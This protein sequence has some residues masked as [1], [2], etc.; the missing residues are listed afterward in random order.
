MAVRKIARLGNPVLRRPA[1]PVE[2]DQQASAIER[3]AEDMVETMREAHGVG[4]SAPQIHEARRVIAVE[5]RLD[6]RYGV[7]DLVDLRVIVNPEIE[8]I[9]PKTAVV[10]EGCL[11]LPGLRGPVKRAQH[12]IVRGVNVNGVPFEEE[13]VNF[14]ATVV[15]H[16]IDHINGILFVD[17]MEDLTL[18]SF[19]DEYHRH[20]LDSKGRTPF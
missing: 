11:S 5:I 12:V 1:E 13:F 17:R 20:Q 2:I 19:E 7:T 6:N 3:I 10:W 18:L 4:I 15:Q 14:A 8:I 9:S 16:E